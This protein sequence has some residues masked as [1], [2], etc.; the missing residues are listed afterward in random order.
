MSDKHTKLFQYLER[1]DAE[2]FKWG[3]MDCCTLAADW[4]VEAVGCDV[5]VD[6]R[7]RYSTALGAARLFKPLGGLST[8][9]SQ[10]MQ[11]N[12]FAEIQP[13][14]AQRGDVALVEFEG[15]HFVGICVGLKVAL[16]SA[17]G[18]VFTMSAT[19]LKAWRI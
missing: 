6:F 14:M 3:A 10:V 16:P 15:R 17:H 12:G 11:A 1:R 18:V 5:Y 2:P 19:P 9:V 8:A 7:G 13:N 4:I